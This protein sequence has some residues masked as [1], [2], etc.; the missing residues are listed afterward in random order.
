MRERQKG[1][2]REQAAASANTFRGIQILGERARFNV[3]AGNYIGTDITGQYA[4]ENH[5]FGVIMEVQASDNVIGGT[6]PAER[7]LISGNVNKGIGISD[8][9]STHNTV[10]GNWIGVDASGTAALGN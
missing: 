7:N 1:R 2:T 10:I 8:P 9:G 6:T 3:V 5:Q 4:L